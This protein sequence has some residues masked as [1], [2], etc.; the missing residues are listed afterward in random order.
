MIQTERLTLRPVEVN[1]A[2]FVLALLNDP[3]FI[4]FIGDREIRNLDQATEYLQDLLK[5][6]KGTLNQLY[7]VV[8]STE[9]T[10]IGITSVRDREELDSPDIGFAFLPEFRGMGYAFEAT[11]A[12]LQH[13]KKVQGIDRVVAIVSPENDRSIFLLEK[14]GYRREGQVQ[15]SSY[16]SC[17][18]LYLPQE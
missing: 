18:I 4:R 7:V 10:P 6:H 15:I 3:D 12:T 1:D 8:L 13:V 11:S 5:K 2:A 16:E 14:L 9:G 17:S